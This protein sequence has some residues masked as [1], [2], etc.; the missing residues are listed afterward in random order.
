VRIPRE[1]NKTGC[2]ICLFSSHA[3]SI[4]KSSWNNQLP[5]D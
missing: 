2:C 1:R 4:T 5:Q 3:S